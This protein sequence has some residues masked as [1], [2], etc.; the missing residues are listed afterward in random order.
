MASKKELSKFLNELSK[1]EL[2]KEFEKLYGKFKEVKTYYNIELSGNTTELL[3][4]AKELIKNQY[5][6][7]R[8][9]GNP[10]ASV[11]K[12]V[13]D[14]FA[15]VSIYPKDLINLNLFRVEQAIAFTAAFG[16]IDMAY[17]TSLGAAFERTL[18]LIVQHNYQEEYK[19]TCKELVDKTEDF[20]WGLHEDFSNL[21]DSYL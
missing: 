16:D 14:D 12:K 13:M 15:K 2:I 5:F 8:G 4:A 11:I 9:Y 21:Y 17:Y 3:K 1:E 18:K 10:K 6:P 19:I 20:G 7:K